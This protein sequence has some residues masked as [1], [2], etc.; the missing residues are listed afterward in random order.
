MPNDQYAGSYRLVYNLTFTG[1]SGA[2]LSITASGVA[3]DLAGFTI[4]GPG[5]LVGN[6]TTA[7][8]ATSSS[9]GIAV[10]NGSISGFFAGVGL[11]GEDSIVEGLRVSGPCPCSLGIGATGIVKGNTVIGTHAA[12]LP[13]LNAASAPIEWIA[14]QGSGRG[15]EGL[16]QWGHYVPSWRGHGR[17]PVG[18]R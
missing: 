3:I 2:C 18:H 14:A 8:A 5:N 6:S 9:D 17:P 13:P 11:G 10:R 15:L 4:S 16:W 7:I 12:L 1:T